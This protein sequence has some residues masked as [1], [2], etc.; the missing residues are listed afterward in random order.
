MA[1]GGNTARSITRHWARGLLTSDEDID[2]LHAEMARAN[3][4]HKK[5]DYSL[6][7]EEISSFSVFWACDGTI[8]EVAPFWVVGPL[9]A[10]LWF[11]LIRKVRSATWTSV[12]TDETSFRAPCTLKPKY[13]NVWLQLRR[14][15][16][17]EMWNV[18]VMNEFKPEISEK[19][20]D[21]GNIS[22]CCQWHRRANIPLS[23]IV[24]DGEAKGWKWNVT[25]LRREKST[26]VWSSQTNKFVQWEMKCSGI[27]QSLVNLRKIQLPLGPFNTRAMKFAAAQFT[28]NQTN[29]HNPSVVNRKTHVPAKRKD[30]W[31]FVLAL[32]V[33]IWDVVHWG[34]V[35]VKLSNLAWNDN[36]NEPIARKMIVAHKSM[37]F[38]SKSHDIIIPLSKSFVSSLE[39]MLAI[40]FLVSVFL[41]SLLIKSLSRSRNQFG[42]DNS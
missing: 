34:T 11:V 17:H 20:W 35:A 38:P 19:L 42:N 41:Q 28:R 36:R 16:R 22:Y 5:Q 21:R 39:H 29:R 18:E 9:W 26:E 7:G 31:T 33:S 1:T 2:G 3:C 8:G 4:E 15:K 23:H 25:Y 14:G 10:H 40:S 24:F 30:L 12:T 6:I 37:N 32:L 13:A 27:N